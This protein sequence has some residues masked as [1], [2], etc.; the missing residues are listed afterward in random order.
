MT[1]FAGGWGHQRAL[2]EILA[3]EKAREATQFDVYASTEGGIGI[4]GGSVPT[5]AD[6]DWDPEMDGSTR[7]R[8]RSEEDEE[9]APRSR[10]VSLLVLSRS[11]I[12]PDELRT[13]LLV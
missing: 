12:V 4:N 11:G 6:G 1:S 13:C 7:K 2:A 8:E 9:D 5:G 10:A 3:Q